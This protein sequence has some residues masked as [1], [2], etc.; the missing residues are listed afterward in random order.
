MSI[1]QRSDLEREDRDHESTQARLAGRLKFACCRQCGSADGMQAVHGDTLTEMP[2]PVL[3]YKR[4]DE[5]EYL[6]YPC[7][8][9]NHWRNIP[10]GYTHASLDDIQNWLNRDPMAP[11][12]VAPAVEEPALASQD[13][14]EGAEI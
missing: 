3:W 9:C 5:V 2:P 10:D 4:L 12:D 11:D 8:Q 1:K 6:F 14:R 7:P 13:S